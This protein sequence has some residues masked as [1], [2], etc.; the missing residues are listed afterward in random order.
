[1]EDGVSLYAIMK[2]FMHVGSPIIILVGVLII[3]HRNYGKI[4]ENI[5]KDVG[6][7]K[8]RIFPRIES[9]ILTL[10]ELLFNVK[11]LIG[12]LCIL[13]GAIFFFLSR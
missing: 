7:I 13:T 1:M 12:I 8:V 6:G 10:H 9:N 11:N 3:L 4:E 2:D 5:N